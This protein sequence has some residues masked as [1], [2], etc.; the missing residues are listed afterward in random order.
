MTYCVNRNINYTNVCTLACTFCA[1]SKGPSAEEL[2]G[3]PYLLSLDEVARR[4]REAWDRGANEVC[5]QG[6]IHPSF[7]GED[8]LEI[9]RAAKRGAP[10]M[11]VHAFSPLEV[12]HGAKTLGLSISDY[13]VALK[14]EGLGSLPGTAAE[15]LHDDVRAKICPDKLTSEEWLRVV[16]TAHAVGIPTTSTM[17]F[18]HVDADGPDAWARHLLELRRVHVSSASRSHRKRES[19]SMDTDTAAASRRHTSVATSANHP[20]TFTEFVPLPFVHFEAPAFRA[21]DARRGPTLRECILVHAVARLTLGPAGVK[22][23]QASWVKMGPEMASL[24]LECGCNDLGGT[25]MNESITRAAGG[26]RGQEFGPQVRSIQTFFTHRPVSTLDR[27]FFQLMTGEPF[28]YGTTL[29]GWRRRYGGRSG[30]RGCGRRCTR[31]WGRGGAR[32]R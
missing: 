6:G 2:R 20:A 27:V 28:L 14:A 18:G 12:T 24:L 26:D 10:E 19:D 13:L 21:G 17:M 7:T 4:T 3:K 22:N 8:Y 31:T 9:L 29:R 30:R 5:M 23:V 16:S 1:F 11:H 25:L 32:W 15:V